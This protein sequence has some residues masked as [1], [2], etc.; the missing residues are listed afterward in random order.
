ME[1]GERRV[2]TRRFLALRLVRYYLVPM[3]RV[4]T[5]APPPSFPAGRTYKSVASLLLPKA[6]L[7]T[8]SGPT[9]LVT[10]LCVVTHALDASRHSIGVTFCIARSSTKRTRRVFPR[11]EWKQGAAGRARRVSTLRLA[12]QL[13]CRTS[14]NLFRY[15][16][17]ESLGLH[18]LEPQVAEDHG[19]VAARFARILITKPEGSPSL[20]EI[21]L[22]AQ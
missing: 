9:D 12:R 17:P 22:Y 11:E 21:E 7:S 16:L 13:Y 4:G 18:L 2:S 20:N 10:M 6:T 1:I 3:L 5:H 14:G 15:E 8:I 19:P